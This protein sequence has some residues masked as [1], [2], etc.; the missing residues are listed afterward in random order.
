MRRLSLLHRLTAVLSSALL[1]QL[2]LLASGTL[3]RM[4]VDQA[5]AQHGV[6]A[7]QHSSQHGAQDSAMAMGD[8]SPAMPMNACGNAGS[9]KSC[10]APWAPSGCASMSSCITATSAMMAPS[11]SLSTA[12]TQVKQFVA[13]AQMPT[14]P[15]FAPELPPP[16]A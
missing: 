10:G 2:S 9:S 13:S 5:N 4:H 16:R 7:A 11:L 6:P 3:C 14:G 1:L 8:D 12:P 15:A